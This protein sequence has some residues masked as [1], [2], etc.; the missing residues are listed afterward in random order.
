MALST[1]SPIVRT[2]PPAQHALT[3]TCYKPPERSHQSSVSPWWWQLI[4]H[5]KKKKKLQCCRAEHVRHPPYN[6]GA[7][8]ISTYEKR[9]CAHCDRGAIMF[10]SRYKSGH[11]GMLSGGV[12]S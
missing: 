10:E 7:H 2:K 11:S 12:I 8:E 3:W 1:S 4:S 6:L 9:L 5:L